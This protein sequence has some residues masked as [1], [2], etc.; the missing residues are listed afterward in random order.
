LG[1]PDVSTALEAP[2]GHDSQVSATGTASNDGTLIIKTAPKT[3]TTIT[4]GA[5]AFQMVG[6]L[7]AGGPTTMIGPMIRASSQAP[8]DD[9]NANEDPEIIIGHPVWELQGRSLS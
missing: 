4:T 6:K 2:E 8:G 9:D 7:V 5:A 1:A 3:D